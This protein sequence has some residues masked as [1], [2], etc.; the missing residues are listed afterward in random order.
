MRIRPS[1][2]H[3]C[4]ICY[5]IACSHRRSP[6][7]PGVD[8]ARADFQILRP[9]W[10]QAPAQ[11]VGR[12]PRGL[13]VESNG[14]HRIRRR[15]VE[16]LRIVQQSVAGA[17]DASDLGGGEVVKEAARTWRDC[18][19]LRNFGQ[20]RLTGDAGGRVRPARNRRGL[21]RRCPHGRA[22]T[23]PSTYKSPMRCPC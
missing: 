19:R 17:E 5:V 23:W 7:G 3:R 13:R 20:G 21:D 8:H 14:E 22:R 10:H 1:S 12:A 4:P 11:C 18:R 15:D 16:A 9:V 2:V 6:L